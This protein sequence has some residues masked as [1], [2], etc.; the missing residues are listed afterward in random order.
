M[1]KL[2][3]ISIEGNKFSI[4]ASIIV[5][6]SVPLLYAICPMCSDWPSWWRT[7]YLVIVIGFF[8]IAWPAVQVS[9]LA[10]I[11][12]LSSTQKDRNDLTSLRSSAQFMSNMLT[13]GI[14]Y[15]ILGSDRSSEEEKTSPDDAYR[16]RVCL[17][18]LKMYFLHFKSIQKMM[19]NSFYS[20]I[21]H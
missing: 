18:F 19:I 20:R 16:F 13:F 8:Q 9:H 14:T 15:F 12:E 4:S 5:F 10:F 11:P 2:G 3:N 17:I 21:Y 1:I 6:I 7:V